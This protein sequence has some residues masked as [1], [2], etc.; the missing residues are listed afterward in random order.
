MYFNTTFANY[1]RARKVHFQTYI[2]ETH[3]KEMREQD[4]TKL[5]LLVRETKKNVVVSLGARREKLPTCE[6]LPAPRATS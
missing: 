5:F 6:R 4:I 3:A 2:S 1:V